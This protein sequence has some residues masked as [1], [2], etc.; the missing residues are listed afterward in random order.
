M[1]PGGIASTMLHVVCFKGIFASERLAYTDELYQER[2][3]ETLAA[4]PVLD[5][6]ILRT[7]TWYTSVFVPKV[8]G[9]T[10]LVGTLPQHPHKNKLRADPPGCIFRVPDN[11]VYF[12]APEEGRRE[13][14]IV[15]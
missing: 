9:R 12:N 11:D 14:N 3:G 2:L 5:K 7:W 6:L 13:A 15:R 8:R 4:A 10:V 1:L